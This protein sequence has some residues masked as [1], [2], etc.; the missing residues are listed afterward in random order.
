LPFPALVAFLLCAWK[1][2]LQNLLD[3]LFSS[4]GSTLQRTVGKS[5]LS[6]ARQKLKA[7]AFVEL[8]QCLLDLAEAHWPTPRWCGL[9]LVACDAT[10]LRLPN[11]LKTA[12]EFGLQHDKHGLPFV[13]ARALGLYDTA[14]GRMFK[15]VLADYHAAERTLLAGLLQD[16]NPNDLLVLDRGYPALWLFA[17]MHQLD[18]PFLARIDG[19]QWPEVQAFTVSGLTEQVVS[20]PLGRDALHRAR[21]QGL[22]LTQHEVSFRLI[23]VLLPSGQVE[24]LATSL[25]DAQLYPATE[26]AA[27]YHQRWGIEEAF[28]VLKHRLN[29]EQFSGEL[30]ESIRQ[31][32]HAKVL[33]ANLAHIMACT[34]QEVL[35]EAKRGRYQVNLAYTLS[36]L[37]P[38]LF[39]WL[40]NPLKPNEV[41]TLLDLI[42]Q[43]LELKRPGRKANRPKSRLNPK[44]RQQY[45]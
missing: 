27:L 24:I 15:T 1:G 13:M 42:G 26:F 19:A 5:A 12:T 2:G 33:T 17:L 28:K 38:R 36:M 25:L 30:P 3:E 18:R 37:R 21:K 43:T 9:R 20:R 32:F 35:P 23:R 11:N 10:T 31:D 7:S 4:L 6:Q 14:S 22:E 40:L 41:L 8:N 29:I 44:P 16:L 34:G 45:K 39:A